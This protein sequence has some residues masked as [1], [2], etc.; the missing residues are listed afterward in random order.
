MYYSKLKGANMTSSIL[1]PYDRKPETLELY[2]ISKS[3]FHLRINEGLIPPP[4]QIGMRAVAFVRTETMA[5]ISAQ[6]AGCSKE[7]IKALVKSLVAQRQELLPNFTNKLPT[8]CVEER[9]LTT[10]T[11]LHEL[12][13][14]SFDNRLKNTTQR[15]PMPNS[16]IFD[17]V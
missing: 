2:K 15:T 3:T 8:K 4:V 7:V 16:P 5:V 10:Q 11:P 1:S 14:G 9:E 12:S 17:E 13:P 6:I